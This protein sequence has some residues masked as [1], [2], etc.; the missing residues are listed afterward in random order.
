MDI[1]KSTPPDILP[2]IDNIP[3]KM[4][5]TIASVYMVVV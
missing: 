5:P 1:F 3:T 4:V 2:D